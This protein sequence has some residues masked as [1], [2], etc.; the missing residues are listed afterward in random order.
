[1]K[2]ATRTASCQDSVIGGGG[3]GGGR[4]GRGSVFGV[5]GATVEGLP[6]RRV[7]VSDHDPVSMLSFVFPREGGGSETEDG[8]GKEE[9]S[10]AFSSSV[11]GGG[12]GVNWHG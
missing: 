7:L 1:M 8:D 10:E 12:G 4:G 11:S 2:V 3:G 6:F 9:D 5:G